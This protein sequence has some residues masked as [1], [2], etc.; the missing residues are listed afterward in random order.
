[1][2]APA[3]WLTTV[4]FLC[5]T[6]THGQ[7]YQ[8]EQDSQMEVILT[9][10]TVNMETETRQLL[11]GAVR[12]VDSLAYKL[13]NKNILS[14][15]ERAVA[16]GVA[17]RVIADPTEYKDSGNLFRE[18][19]KAG[20]NVKVYDGPASQSKLHAKGTI[21]DRRVVLT[22][23]PNWT[24]NEDSLE[25]ILIGRA[26]SFIDDMQRAFDDLWANHTSAP[27]A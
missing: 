11:D 2:L 20:A 22:G 10:P 17:V 23:S 19:A 18:L 27:R 12:S 7:Q 3:V 6:A 21:Y 9:S 25:L 24:N 26:P 16:R 4:L 13:K 15:L 5:S 8:H 14:A 1:M